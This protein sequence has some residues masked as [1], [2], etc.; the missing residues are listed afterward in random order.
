M[1]MTSNCDVTNSAHQIQM[2]TICHWM[3]TP[4]KIFC[5]RHCCNVYYY[6]AQHRGIFSVEQ[7]LTT[8]KHRPDVKNNINFALTAISSLF[9][10]TKIFPVNL[11]CFCI[12][13]HCWNNNTQQ[14]KSCLRA[15]V[16][17]CLLNTI[18]WPLQKL[19]LFLF[20]SFFCSNGSSKTPT[21]LA[22]LF[23][24]NDPFWNL[25]TALNNSAYVSKM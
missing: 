14:W 6:S 9:R 4:M 24:N 8:T 25:S 22:L 20:K 21:Y 15:W 23:Y 13:R 10:A 18:A 3:Q 19:A 2:T 11:S 5:V 1:N 17:T 16:Q 7:R 12:K